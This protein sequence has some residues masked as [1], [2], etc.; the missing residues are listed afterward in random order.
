MSYDQLIHDYEVGGEKLRNATK[1]LLLE[2]LL[3]CPMPGTW[4]L[5]RV[6][7]TSSFS[8]RSW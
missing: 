5:M 3:A 6:S 4:S 7:T 2:D 8:N 1:G